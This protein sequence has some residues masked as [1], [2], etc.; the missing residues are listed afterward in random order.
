MVKLVET[1]TEFELSPTLQANEMVAERR[2]KGEQ[3]LHMGFGES[4][5]SCAG[6]FG[7]SIGRSGTP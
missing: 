4:P 3:V 5:V 6:A 2:A 1:A 7:K